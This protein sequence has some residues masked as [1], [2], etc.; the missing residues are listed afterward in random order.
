MSAP[1][2]VVIVGIVVSCCLQNTLAHAEVVDKIVAILDEELI[3]L[4]KVRECLNNPAARMLANFDASSDQEQAAL[5]YLIE[6]Q[7]LRREIQ[8]LA[9]PKEKEVVKSLA[10]TYIINTYYH[11]DAQAFAEKVRTQGVPDEALEQELLLSMKGIDYIRRKYRF[12][13]DI[14]KPDIVLNLFQQWVKDLQARA[15]IQITF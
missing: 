6:Q 11:K 3:L 14:D 2:F 8:Y 5:H 10:T 4:S 13:A 9:F 1:K 12:N 7:L 15:K